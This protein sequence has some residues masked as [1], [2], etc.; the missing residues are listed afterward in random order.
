MIELCKKGSK[1][2]SNSNGIEENSRAEEFHC[3][4]SK[5]LTMLLKLVVSRPIYLC[6]DSLKMLRRG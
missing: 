1:P 6:S 4:F 5:T 3:I 2:H